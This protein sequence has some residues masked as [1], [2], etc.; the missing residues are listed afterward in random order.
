MRAFLIAERVHDIAILSIRPS[1]APRVGLRVR[2]K[3]VAALHQRFW[4]EL[5]VGALSTLR[6]VLGQ[7]RSRWNLKTLGVV[8]YLEQVAQV[9]SANWLL[10]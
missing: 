7:S 1:R 6:A 3:A 8:V 5:E 10:I 2:A 4:A 9:D